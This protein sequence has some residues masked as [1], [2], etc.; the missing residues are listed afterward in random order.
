MIQ[1]NV[2]STMTVDACICADF[3]EFPAIVA[4]HGF[5]DAREFTIV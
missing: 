3:P 2:S 4:M 5:P 1:P